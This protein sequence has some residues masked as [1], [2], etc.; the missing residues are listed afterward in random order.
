MKK[1]KYLVETN[2]TSH[3]SKVNNSLWYLERPKYINTNQKY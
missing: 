2:S 1:N 3:L